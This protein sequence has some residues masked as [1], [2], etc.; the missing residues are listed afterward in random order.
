M[1]EVCAVSHQWGTGSRADDGC[2][3]V[4]EI[5]FRSRESD[6]EKNALVFLLAQG[7]EDAHAAYREAD[8]AGKRC[9]QHDIRIEMKKVGDY[10]T[11][12][13]DQAQDIQGQ[14]RVNALVHVFA[15]PELQEE[16]R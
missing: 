13:E 10:S 8:Y 15:K 16:R 4:Q 9:D 1:V 7:A 11:D 12:C 2:R 5:A 3:R 14:G 6:E